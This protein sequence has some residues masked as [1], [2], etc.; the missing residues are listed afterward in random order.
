MRSAH[1]AAVWLLVAALPSLQSPANAQSSIGCATITDRELRGICEASMRRYLRCFTMSGQQRTQ[2]EAAT[3]EELMALCR[4]MRPGRAGECLIANRNGELLAHHQHAV[5]KGD[6]GVCY[7]LVT[8]AAADLQFKAAGLR[9]LNG[10][11]PSEYPGG[12]CRLLAD[13]HTAL[14]GR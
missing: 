11:K 7:Q 8:I 13:I 3:S 9:V 14:N 12:G 10:R 4:R 6:G 5:A 2:C 1:L